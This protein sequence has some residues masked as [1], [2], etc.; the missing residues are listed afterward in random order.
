MRCGY[1]RP[2][3]KSFF[4]RGMPLFFCCMAD[5]QAQLDKI[6]SGKIWNWCVRHPCWALAVLSMVTL[7]PFL[8]KPFNIDDPC[9]VWSAKQILAHPTAPYSFSVN[10]NGTPQPMW[11]VTQ[12]P[13]L[14]CYLIALA[15]WLFGGNEAGIH[16]FFL[17]PVIAVVLGTFRLAG[18]F[19]RSPAFAAGMTLFMPA[20]LVSSTTV[21]CDVPMLAWWIWAVVFWV[22]GTSQNK[23]LK[24]VAAGSLMALAAMTKYNAV[25]LIPL[26]AAYSLVSGRW[27]WRWL[28]CLLIPIATIAAYQIIT[29][30]LY[31]FALLS[32]ASA[33]AGTARSTFHFSAINSC[34]TA[35]TFIGGCFAPAV[36]LLPFL[37]G[38]RTRSWLMAGSVGF[39]AMMV[40]N[41]PIQE[42]YVTIPA[43]Q[44]F[45][46]G[47]QIIFWMAGGNLL[48]ALAVREVWRQRDATACLLTFWILGI[49]LFAAFFNW[50]VNARTL[51]PMTPAVAIL[52]TRCLERQFSVGGAEK[53]FPSPVSAV[54]VLGAM[55]AILL[56]HA[57]FSQA[58]AVRSTAR[59][60]TARYGTG[61][62]TL[63]FDGNWG[64][65]YYME[66][67]GASGVD[68][69][70]PQLKAGDILALPLNNSVLRQPDPERATLQDAITAPGDA[71][72]TTMSATC[73][74]GFYAATHGPLPF[75]L[76]RIPP[77]CVCVFAIHEPRLAPVSK[78]R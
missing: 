61:A 22:E 67:G 37:A 36:F 43:G 75:A 46:V 59:A 62:G 26:L 9:Y 77:E 23:T 11:I 25:C 54:F 41:G 40:F 72:F 50:T 24:L 68:I 29:Q 8:A 57:D 39:A 69:K 42:S 10:W 4:R 6:R 60:V 1:P 48:L 14:D 27:S 2:V 3:Q 30:K 55:L 18:N 76:G 5:L 49:F 58:V 45:I 71:W 70:Q 34:Q 32:Q 66:Q 20:F 15:A 31:G 13:P 19:C 17:L 35:L 56:A 16:L 53:T 38:G 28:L 21:M 33:Y 73:G 65:Q 7:A 47:L 12:N 44:K 64:Y 78:S 52:L 74:A 51:L 63:W